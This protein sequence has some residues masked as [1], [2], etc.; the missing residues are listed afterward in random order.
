[1]PIFINNVPVSIDFFSPFT[2]SLQD[3]PLAVV[4]IQLDFQNR[5]IQRNWTFTLGLGPVL[6]NPSY[7]DIPMR[8]INK[9][10]VKCK[11]NKC[12]FYCCVLHTK[13]SYWQFFWL[14]TK[15]LIDF[16]LPL[17]CSINFSLNL[18]GTGLLYLLD[19]MMNSSLHHLV[20][21][22]DLN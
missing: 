4:L 15:Y 13:L 2:P 5:V 1:M 21:H 9:C 22:L 16:L 3:K 11:H 7:F 12:K 6:N 19:I 18:L 17:K 8:L 14:A 10:Y 20:C